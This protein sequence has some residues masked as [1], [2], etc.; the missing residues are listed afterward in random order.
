MDAG[1]S[2]ALPGSACV[3]SNA[4]FEN[5]L[6]ILATELRGAGAW[7]WRVFEETEA[8]RQLPMKVVVGLWFTAWAVNAGGSQ[9][10]SQDGVLAP[11]PEFFMDL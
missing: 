11:H 4:F 8:A 7:K 10:G 2:Y 3:L 9:A 1:T 6:V 5:T